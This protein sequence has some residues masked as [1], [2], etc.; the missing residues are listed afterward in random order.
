MICV[1][2]Q[3]A[4]PEG[5]RDDEEAEDVA[6]SEQDFEP[7]RRDDTFRLRDAR[8]SQVQFGKDCDADIRTDHHGDFR[9]AS[10]SHEGAGKSV[11]DT[12]ALPGRMRSVA[13]RKRF[14]MAEPRDRERARDS[15]SDCSPLPRLSPVYS[16]KG[17]GT[18]VTPLSATTGLR[19]ATS[20]HRSTWSNCWSRG[21]AMS[22]S[23]TMT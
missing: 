1:N 14:S 16:S 21:A 12:T 3:R 17:G 10:I 4:D 11:G 22:L 13:M 20:G 15:G 5:L 23:K 2:V 18:G 7:G 6:A 8:P 19:T 9:E